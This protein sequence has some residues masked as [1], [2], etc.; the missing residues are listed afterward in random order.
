MNMI[1]N[2]SKKTKYTNEYGEEIPVVSFDAVG[3]K[4]LRS[5]TSYKVGQVV[6][7]NWIPNGL[8]AWGTVE[9]GNKLN[10]VYFKGRAAII[11]S[12]DT[13]TV[14]DI[15]EALKKASA[16]YKIETKRIIHMCA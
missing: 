3:M 15:N 9:D 4:D 1:R 6:E 12:F 14:T 11:T 7:N 5:L 8:L 2:L 16:L 10:F 13:D